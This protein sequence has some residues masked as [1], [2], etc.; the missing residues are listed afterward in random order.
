[1]ELRGIR[2]DVARWEHAVAL[3][4]AEK[5]AIEQQL[6]QELSATLLTSR[7]IDYE[8]ALQAYKDWHIEKKAFEQSLMQSY[9]QVASK[10]TWQ[11][12][13]QERMAAWRK[14]HPEP[15]KP[16]LVRTP[17]NLS[18]HVQVCEALHA[19]GIPVES[20]QDAEL[21]RYAARYPIVEKF[22]TWRDLEHFVTSFGKNLLACVEDDG[23]IHAHFGQLGA[24]SGR[25]ICREPNLQQIPR[26]GKD[27]REDVNLRR[28]F[29]AADGCKL[30]VVDL[31]NIELRILADV[32]RDPVMLRLFSE[33]RDL[34]AETA[35]LMFHL[36]PETDTKQHCY[37]GVS[38]RN[39]AK[40]INF[41][42][43]YGMGAASLGERVG[44]DEATAKQL[45]RDYFQ[46]YRGVAAYLKAS[47]KQ[48][49][50]QGYATTLGGRK[51]FLPDGG[52]RMKS[53]LAGRME[54]SAKNHPIQGTNA[55]ILKRA[56]ALLHTSMPAGCHLVLT[57]HDEIVLEA[58]LARVSE[59]EQ[60]LK[61]TMV[62]ACR[63]FLS[64]VAVPEPEVL[65]GDYWQKD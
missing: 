42:L 54:R 49:L 50:A 40:T 58:P 12:Y 33:G 28:C 32:S 39:I 60:L 7:M 13:H 52:Q 59:A 43:V 2:V 4:E 26:P 36:P 15:A 41:G 46:T 64:V 38:V 44:L 19:V 21:S 1:M 3:K 29:I 6:V 48:A 56:L 61:R 45:V 57:V 47:P 9:R 35:K 65:V 31:P 17:I 25:I 27:E 5:A 37:K 53:A 20:T 23:R 62:Q 34:H 16:V 11:R 63:E 30:L 10:Y 18:S 14:E 8:D 55:D 51:R 22:R 24:V